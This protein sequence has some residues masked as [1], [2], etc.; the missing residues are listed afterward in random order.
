MNLQQFAEYAQNVGLR[1]VG[2]GAFGTMGDFPVV[3][4]LNGGGSGNLAVFV[5][6]A[7]PQLMKQNSKSLL[8]SLRTALKGTASV[9]TAA[10]SITFNI[11]A[12][13]QTLL[14]KIQDTQNIALPILREYGITP[15]QVCRICGQGGCDSYAGVYGGYRPVHARCVQAIGEKAQAEYQHNEQNGSY[16]R[17]ILGAVLGGLIAAVPNLLT[18]WFMEVMYSLLYA[19]IPLGAYFGY[20][21]LGGKMNKGGVAVI[22]I[23]SVVV[24]LLIDPLII[25]IAFV[26]EGLPL[27]LLPYLLSNNEFMAI[28]LPESM[29]SLLF[30]ALGIFIV[31]SKISRTA[32][33][34]VMDVQ[35]VMQTLQTMPGIQL[36]QPVQSVP[37]TAASGAASCP[38]DDQ[39]L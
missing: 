19:L 23:V 8:K 33:H 2:A 6:A 31:W 15:P 20:K 24:G 25:A 28:L 29:K 13:P 5:L 36:E 37:G 35:Q 26:E 27:A 17:G 21:K 14:Q 12:K 11:A 18:I 7:D 34:S 10:D 16:A 39:S 32:A 1:V 22:C 30:V 38:S 3:A 4:S 9:N